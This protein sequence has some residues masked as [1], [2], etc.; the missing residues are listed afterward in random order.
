MIIDITDVKKKFILFLKKKGVYA[1]Y[2]KN[3]SAKDVRYFI[4]NQTIWD[5][6]IR[7]SFNWGKTKEGDAFWLNINNTWSHIYKNRKI[8][9]CNIKTFYHYVLYGK[10]IH[11]VP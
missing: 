3:L 5:E 11:N 8:K 9:K 6:I 1:S 7:F 2:R 10:G 4:K